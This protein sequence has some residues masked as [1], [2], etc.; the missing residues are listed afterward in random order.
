MSFLELNQRPIRLTPFP[1]QNNF[2]HLVKH[3]P[4][5]KKVTALS[6]YGVRETLM[7]SL[8]CREVCAGHHFRKGGNVSDPDAALMA[9]EKQFSHPNTLLYSR[10]VFGSEHRTVTA[11]FEL[12]EVQSL[13][14]DLETRGI[15]TDSKKV[16]ATRETV[17]VVLWMHTRI[18]LSDLLSE[19]DLE[20]AFTEG[21]KNRAKIMKRIIREVTRMMGVKCPN[22]ECD[23]C[24]L[25][26]RPGVRSLI[27]SNHKNPTEKKKDKYDSPSEIWANDKIDHT[28]ER[29]RKRRMG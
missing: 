26:F 2:D 27:E 16:P 22:N 18:V 13:I 17:E 25:N 8:K 23:E 21:H 19:S 29:A 14:L 1:A 4:K 28:I 7:E 20:K 5:W 10:E 9:Y 11:A 24:Y 12:K 3:Y 6:L 15:M